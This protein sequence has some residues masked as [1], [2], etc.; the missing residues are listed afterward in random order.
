[1]QY[2]M[3]DGATNSYTEIDST[4]SDCGIFRVC[5]TEDQDYNSRLLQKAL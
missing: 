4:E 2:W 1:M 5:S 3:Y